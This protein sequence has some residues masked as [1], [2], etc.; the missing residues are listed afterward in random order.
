MRIGG[1]SGAARRWDGPLGEN[2]GCLN[3]RRV[4]LRGAIY[5]RG[6]EVKRVL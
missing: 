6:A 4:W 3:L 5:P 2:A 1:I